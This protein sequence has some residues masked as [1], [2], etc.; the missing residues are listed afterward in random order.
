M[1]KFI[2]PIVLIG[3]ITTGVLFPQQRAA[4]TVKIEA[5]ALSGGPTSSTDSTPVRIDADLYVPTTTPAPAIILAHGFGGNKQSV[6]AEAKYFANA[7]FVVL[8]YT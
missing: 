2:F 7:G 1:K 3:L 6:A 8:A 5:I 4:A